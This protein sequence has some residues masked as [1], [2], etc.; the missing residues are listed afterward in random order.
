MMDD[1]G[2]PQSE[3]TPNVYFRAAD[4][5]ILGHVESR[6][7]SG[8]L[9]QF[10]NQVMQREAPPVLAQ[11]FLCPYRRLVQIRAGRRRHP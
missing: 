9:R 5:R 6:P 7:L 11:D 4:I 10:V 1:D 2:C 3:H 8:L